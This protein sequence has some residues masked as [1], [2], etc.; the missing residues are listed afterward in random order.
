MESMQQ[1]W[2][3][4]AGQAWVDTQELLDRLFQP[5]ESILAA[6]AAG[7]VLDVGCGAGATTR[8]VGDNCTGID[9]SAPMIAA[10]QQR[11]AARF[12]CADA[13]T[14]PFAPASFDT[15]VS[16]FG[17][18]FF[19]DPVAAFTNLHRAARENAA[20]ALITWR[21][22]EDN[23]FMTA[24]ERAA[25]PLLPELPVRKKDEPGQFGLA[26]PARIHD[27]LTQ[28]GWRDIGIQPLDIECA[29]PE[30]DL[31]R[32]IARLGPVGLALVN[33]DG[34]TRARVIETVLSAFECYRKGDEIRFM[35]ACWMIRAHKT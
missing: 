18:M 22:P 6:E 4:D 1:L 2:N 34:Q 29:M 11:C 15:I 33:A 8:A 24:A 9:I 28:S 14:Y 13:Q 23:P 25:A 27:I 5:F 16:R 30:V 3:G 20:C 35:A 21:S 17:V 10:A 12:I 7:D 31:N 26:D 32:Y 19:A